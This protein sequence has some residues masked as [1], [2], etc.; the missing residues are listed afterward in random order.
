MQLP[1]SCLTQHRPTRSVSPEEYSGV[2]LG[3]LE[4]ISDF[5][6][7]FRVQ[8]TQST[9]SPQ[10]TPPSL[11][12][13]LNRRTSRNPNQSNRAH[14]SSISLLCLLHLLLTFI[15]FLQL[16]WSFRDQKRSKRNLKRSM[17]LKNILG[18]HQ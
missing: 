15:S 5:F 6:L 8:S 1:C 17:K 16:K 9:Q 11:V 2:L 14:R 10:I 18:N 4:K 12:N 13:L 7:L 3:S